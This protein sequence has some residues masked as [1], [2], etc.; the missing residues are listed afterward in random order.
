MNRWN[1]PDWLEHDVIQ[2]DRACVYCG[3]SFEIVSSLVGDRPSWEH[4]VNDAGIITRE[5]IV[6]CCRSCNSSKGTKS[7]ENWLES[8][9]CKRRGITE[10]TVAKVVQQL[11]ENTGKSRGD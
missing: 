9:Y 11:L 4:I 6:R 10:H 3:V 5:N 2:R 7:L 8:S 1:I